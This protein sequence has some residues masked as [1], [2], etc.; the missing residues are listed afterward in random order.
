MRVWDIS[1]GYLNRASLLGEHREI[2][3]LWV[4]IHKQ[5]AGYRHHPETR[6]WLNCPEALVLRHNMVVAEMSL[7]GW[8]HHSPLPDNT[9]GGRPE[10]WVNTP[11]EQL[12]LLAKKYQDKEMG[13]LSLPVDNRQMWAQHKYS[14]MARDP[15]LY[16]DLGPRL[17]KSPLWPELPLILSQM[18]LTAPPQGRLRN[19]LE[20]M[21]GYLP[22]GEKEKPA[23][24]LPL[25]MAIQNGAYEHKIQYL[26]QSTALG[27][28]R[29]WLERLDGDQ[30]SKPAQS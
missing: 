18:L 1:P 4:V 24:L 25:L 14:I 29:C 17:G 7:R 20:H 11:Q 9:A 13:R 21:W 6:R 27:E 19:A 15:A 30:P 16:R 3:A 28:L 12:V 26:L 8:Q 10:G 23:G 22:R 5:N 2:H